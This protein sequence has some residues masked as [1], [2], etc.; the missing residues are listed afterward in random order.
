MFR[1]LNF[2]T[3]FWQLCLV[4]FILPF[5]WSHYVEVI[6]TVFGIL[7]PLLCLFSF[8]KYICNTNASQCLVE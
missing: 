1:H 6:H 8:P 7:F 5:L 2:V 4:F 3:I